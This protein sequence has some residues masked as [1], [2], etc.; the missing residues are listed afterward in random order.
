MSSSTQDVAPDGGSGP[1]GQHPGGGS[2]NGGPPRTG[3]GP[4]SND[5]ASG[6]NQN[7]VQ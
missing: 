4:T 5:N 7:H 1:P 3:P 6:I 2:N